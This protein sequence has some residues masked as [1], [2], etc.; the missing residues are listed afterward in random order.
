MA[1]LN[2]LPAGTCNI[3]PAHTEISFVA[4]HLMVTKVRG[5]FTDY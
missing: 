3:D 1:S 4:R 2:T 5:K